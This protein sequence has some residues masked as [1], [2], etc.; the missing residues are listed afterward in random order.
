LTFRGAE[1]VAHAAVASA[2]RAPYARVALVNGAVAIIVAPEGHLRIVL[3]FT[4]DGERVTRVDV[5]A[6]P[7]RLRSLE[8]AVLD[9]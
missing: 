6:D 7:G 1:Q 2:A 9:E 3:A 5:I 8:V 4:V